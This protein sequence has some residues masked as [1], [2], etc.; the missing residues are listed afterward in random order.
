MLG[1]RGGSA[2]RWRTLGLRVGNGG[3]SFFGLRSCCDPLN[4][5]SVDSGAAGARKGLLLAINLEASRALVL[6]VR[7][8][9]GE[10]EL[11]SPNGSPER[12]AGKDVREPTRRGG[13]LGGF[14]GRGGRL[15]R[16]RCPSPDVDA[17]RTDPMRWGGGGGGLF[18]GSRGSGS[19]AKSALV[20]FRCSEA[21]PVGG[22]FVYHDHDSPGT[23]IRSTSIRLRSRGLATCPSIRRTA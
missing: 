14:G 17:E 9:I 7:V 6:R 21:L 20:E 11:S 2:G 15:G 5:S 16:R 1:R 23:K 8:L 22:C 12:L 13:G 3:P 4:S 18:F 10:P 19:T